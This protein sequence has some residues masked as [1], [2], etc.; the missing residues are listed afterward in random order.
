MYPHD[1]SLIIGSES[2]EGNYSLEISCVGNCVTSCPALNCNDR[3]KPNYA[4]CQCKCETGYG[5][6]YCQ[7]PGN[8]QQKSNMIT[9]YIE[10][11][12]LYILIFLVNQSQLQ[13]LKTLICN[14]W[15][16]KVKLVFFLIWN[17]QYIVVESQTYIFSTLCQ[18]ELLQWSWK[19]YWR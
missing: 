1:Y 12:C 15:S 5:G 2:S 3:G 14:C 17:P 6:Y 11:S 9:Q 16:T 19:L 18:F 4:T 13:R 7:R 8:G 10:R